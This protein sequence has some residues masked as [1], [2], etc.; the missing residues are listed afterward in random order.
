MTGHYVKGSARGTRP[1]RIM[2]VVVESQ[3]VDG[4]SRP[5]LRV[6]K[7][8][9]R[10]FASWVYRKNNAW[11]IPC[12]AV[13][14]TAASF[15]DH[16]ERASQSKSRC[17]VV[18]PVASDALTLAQFW[19]RLERVGAVW[20]GGP[21]PQ[22]LSRPR[23]GQGEPY[24][25][26]KLICRGKP[27][28]IEYSR[29]GASW[30]WVSGCQYLDL[31]PDELAAAIGYVRDQ[32]P[33]PGAGEGIGAW[34]N[35]EL[36]RLWLAAMMKLADWW[37][38]LNAGPFPKSVPAAAAAFMRS[39]TPKKGL[40]THTC[41]LT[42][43]LERLACHGGRASVWDYRHY[44]PLASGNTADE[45]PYP[46]SPYGAGRGPLYHLDYSSMYPHILADH[47]FPT[48]RMSFEEN[49]SI[50]D[51]QQMCSHF[52]VVAH[53]TIDT[54]TAEYPH[55]HHD[56]V[57]YP[58]G[59]YT[60]TLATPEVVSALSEG[61]VRAVHAVAVYAMGRPYVRA[62]DELIAMREECKRSGNQGWELFTKLLS[63]SLTG[64]LAMR[65]GQWV[66]RPDVAAERRWG[67]WLIAM[68]HGV[69]PERYRGMAGLVW[70]MVRD[71]SG[72]GT[73]TAGYAHITSYGRVMMRKLREACPPRSVV[74]QD[75]DG[76]WVTGA[77]RAA[78]LATA[79]TNAVS[80]STLVEKRTARFA[81]FW[82]P[83]HYH[84]DGDWVAA[85]LHCPE[86]AYQISKFT[87]TTS[88]N[89]CHTSPDSPPRTI[90]EV[91][92]VGSL[93]L[94]AVDC[95]IGPDGY[96]T[97]LV[98]PFVPGQHHGLGGGGGG[99]GGLWP[100]S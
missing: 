5:S 15:W 1:G 12:S 70:Q 24:S 92:R 68:P 42:G 78:L 10:I 2:S 46:P 95:T 11:S 99:G 82:G 41:K 27:D 52:C 7:T 22:G 38:P 16:L 18:A 54:P 35:R 34:T 93:E 49:V 63:N 66:P 91:T 88:R 21:E 44:C 89:G 62:A 75:T 37:A 80:T 36:S 6:D 84:I 4:G 98:F 14:G 76:V 77:G 79:P 50:D 3:P 60:T 74:Q 100:D 20:T 83:K 9:K 81:R 69:A 48:K 59:S 51:L 40:C 31:T 47:E 43:A 26:R 90:T 29:S 17:L 64:R 67:E 53:V 13:F 61:H 96:A 86:F 57:C 45:L 58:T 23:S 55:R 94:E 25:I 30:L 28:I 19:D 8:F 71:D 72:P 56:R 73:L 39:R 32:Q 87:D 85:G 97:P 33:D 65:N